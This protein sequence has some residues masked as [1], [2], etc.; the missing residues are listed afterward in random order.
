MP[1]TPLVIQLNIITVVA[2]HSLLIGQQH[3]TE[4]RR[5]LEIHQNGYEGVQKGNF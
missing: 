2:Y 5:E 4:E 1:I 3:K